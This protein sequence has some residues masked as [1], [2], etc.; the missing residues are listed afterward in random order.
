MVRWFCRTSSSVSRTCYR[1]KKLNLSKN[2]NFC[3]KKLN[4]SAFTPQFCCAIIKKRRG[5]CIFL[6]ETKMQ[7]RFCFLRII[8]L[9]LDLTIKILLVF[10]WKIENSIWL[11]KAIKNL[12][13][14]G[15]K[16][17]SATKIMVRSPTT[18][19]HFWCSVWPYLFVNIC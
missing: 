6:P 17:G 3:K 11:K 13:K 19:K 12:Q 4:L 14:F 15:K 7:P 8:C 18:N 10:N 16:F 1:T 9:A 2:L 5:K